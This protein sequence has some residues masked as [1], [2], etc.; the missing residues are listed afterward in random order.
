MTACIKIIFLALAISI[1]SISTGFCQKASSFNRDSL[2]VISKVS[3][4][5]L[6]DASI[7]LLKTKKLS[8]ISDSGHINIMMC[9]NTIFM[10][11][12]TSFQKRF[13]SER[14]KQLKQL[15]EQKKYSREITKVYPE[16]IPNRGMGFYFPNFKWNFME[17][18]VCIAG[19]KLKSKTGYCPN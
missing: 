9:L 5:K 4:D 6:V 15:V 8:E 11:R 7:D 16:W 18:R 13:T 19:F 1:L 12:D 2:K 3:F 14:Y 10:T 17:R